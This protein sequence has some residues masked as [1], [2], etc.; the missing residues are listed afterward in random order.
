MRV[1]YLVALALVVEIE[2]QVWLSAGT[3]DRPAKSV[4]GAIV[5]LA[6]LRPQ[7]RRNGACSR[8]FPAGAGMLAGGVRRVAG[9]LVVVKG[10][11]ARVVWA[12]PGRRIACG[13]ALAVPI[14]ALVVI[15]S[16]APTASQAASPV[17]ARAA[18]QQTINAEVNSLIGRMTVAEKFG[19]L[20]MA[21]PDGPNGAPGDLI[22]EAETGRSVPFLTWWA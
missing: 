15:A 16:G 1:D 20:E 11:V 17:L 3:P 2:L 19:Q 22:T 7:G 5:A 9:V 6:V 13:T 10:R 12:R 21:A 4:G 14:A 8:G 18:D